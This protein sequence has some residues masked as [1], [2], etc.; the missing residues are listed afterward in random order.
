[1]LPK[2][3]ELHAPHPSFKATYLKGFE[4]LENDSDR[5]AWVYLGDTAP[6]DVPHKDFTGYVQTLQQR[7]TNP[8]P[9][10]VC[11]TTYWAISQ[12][13]MVGRISVRH[14]LNEFL[15]KV[16][17]HI[18]YIVRPSARGQGV[19]TEM[20]K[21]VLRAPVARSIGKLLLTCDEANLASERTI[22]K[23]GG[24]F[25]SIVEVGSHRARK[26]HFWITVS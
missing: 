22:L 18:G 13:E 8:P 1:M 12:G 21:Q 19:A 25:H 14:E 16:G 2:D 23:C 7:Q 17:G 11:D 3:I 24:V 20:L 5:S 15:S 4:E 10:F 6:R 26:K 9:G